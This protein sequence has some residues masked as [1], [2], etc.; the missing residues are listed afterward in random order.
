MDG[1]QTSLPMNTLKEIPTPAP[2]AK[3]ITG[4]QKESG[5]VTGYQ[6]SDGRVLD[7]EAAVGLARQGGIAGVGIATRN[8]N[9][10]LKSLP[11]GNEDNNL[12]SL[13]TV[14]Q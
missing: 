10:Y 8:G 13:P 6:M 11:D 1:K 7:K 12:S 3:Q 4:L 5:R 14:S 9:E 2:D